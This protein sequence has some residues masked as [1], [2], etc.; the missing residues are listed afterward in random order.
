MV[1]GYIF[2][3]HTSLSRRGNL[4]YLIHLQVGY[5]GKFVLS[6][7]CRYPPAGVPFSLHLCL[8]NKK[9]LLYLCQNEP[10]VNNLYRIIIFSI[11]WCRVTF[12]FLAP[13]CQLGERWGLGKN[14]YYSHPHPDIPSRWGRTILKHLL[15]HY[16]WM[17]T[18]E[19]LFSM[20]QLYCCSYTQPQNWKKHSKTTMR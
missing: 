3:P 4:Y 8:Q 6:Y 11:W 20:L 16:L 14:L 2:F 18:Y 15:Y 10:L 1:L 13:I 5:Q 17:K 7:A 19:N 12:Y 9:I